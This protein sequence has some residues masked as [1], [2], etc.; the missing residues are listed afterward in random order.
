MEFIVNF[1]AVEVSVGNYRSE[2][3][4]YDTYTTSS[5]TPEFKKVGTEILSQLG[6]SAKEVKYETIEKYSNNIAVM[7]KEEEAIKTGL[8]KN[9]REIYVEVSFNLLQQFFEIILKDGRL[10]YSPIKDKLLEFWRRNSY[11]LLIL[12]D[13]DKIKL[14]ERENKRIEIEKAKEKEKQE[15]EKREQEKIAWIKE[16]GSQYL[17]DCLELGQYAHKEYLLERS[18]FEFPGFILDYDN[19]A[20]W[21]KIYSPSQKALDELKKLR[22]TPNIDSDIVLLTEHPSNAEDFQSCE[23]VIVKYWLGKYNLINT[24][25]R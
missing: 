15:K 25:R 23:A 9:S 8:F 20:D 16:H 22:K 13:E 11:N 21:E 4:Q 10:I 14:Q 3:Q 17:K 6:I 2:K 18:E 1:K 12:S 24:V 7:I 19:G 5:A